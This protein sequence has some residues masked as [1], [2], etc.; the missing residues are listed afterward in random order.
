MR[1]LLVILS[2]AVGATA[3]AA[4]AAQAHNG[5]HGTT[6]VIR[7]QMHGCHAW[8]LDNGPYRAALVVRLHAGSVLTFRNNDVM[9]HT[10]VQ[11]S[12]P[13]VSYLGKRLMNHVG[14]ALQAAFIKPGVYRFTTRAGDD[15]TKG[16]ETKGPDYVLTLKVVVE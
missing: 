8:S 14:A 12:G 7:H 10:L 3:L 11:T 15:Y 6:I 5:P 4:S 1:R 2:L 16:M 13:A 9:P